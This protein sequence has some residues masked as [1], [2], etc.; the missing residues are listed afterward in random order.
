MQLWDVEAI[1]HKEK[2]LL[3]YISKFA[4]YSS[5]NLVLIVYFAFKNLSNALIMTLAIY[6]KMFACLLPYHFYKKFGILI[7]DEVVNN[8]KYLVKKD[9]A[10]DQFEEFEY[11]ENNIV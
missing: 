9:E 3:I 10:R 4:F 1:T 8:Y 6:S 7:T 5:F 2:N 11:D